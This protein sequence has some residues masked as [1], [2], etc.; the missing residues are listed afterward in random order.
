M[1]A[2]DNPS[3]KFALSSPKGNYRLYEPVSQDSPWSTPNLAS[4]IA[5]SFENL[6]SHS[7]ADKECP[8]HCLNLLSQT[9]STD[10][11]SNVLGYSVDKE[12]LPAQSYIR[13]HLNGLLPRAIYA[14]GS[15]FWRAG[16]ALADALGLVDEIVFNPLKSVSRPSRTNVSD[17]QS[18][19]EWALKSL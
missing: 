2:V 15:R 5:D 14:N 9:N 10:A 1:E 17:A 12:L 6:V 13:S 18:D 11:I 19:Y 3:F 4:W 7:V 8:P 16:V